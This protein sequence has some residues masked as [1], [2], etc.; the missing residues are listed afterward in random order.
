MHELEEKIRELSY[1]H[2]RELAELRAKVDMLR[3]DVERLE[4]RISRASEDIGWLKGRG[5]IVT[6]AVTAMR[7]TLDKLLLRR[8]RSRSDSSHATPSVPPPAS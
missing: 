3:T 2:G 4:P 8:N 1:N 6:D 5:E 7:K